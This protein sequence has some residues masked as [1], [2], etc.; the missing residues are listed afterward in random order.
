MQYPDRFLRFPF[1][2]SPA[3][4]QRDHIFISRDRISSQYTDF[5][6]ISGVCCN[7]RPESAVSFKHIER[8]E[9]YVL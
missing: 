3:T 1:Q 5:P 4:A 7:L 6:V 8:E 2:S 9:S